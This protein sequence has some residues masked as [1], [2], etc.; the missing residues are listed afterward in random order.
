[1]NY[2]R[3]MTLEEQERWAYAM[4]N[5]HDAALFARGV[6]GD[7]ELILENDR[8][9]SL[10]EESKRRAEDW[11]GDASAQEE[12]ADAYKKRLSEIKDR[13]GHIIATV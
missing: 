1:M 9:E 10:L 13:L 5:T 12:R 4:G 6:E 11:A 7:E 8:L 3:N 2:P